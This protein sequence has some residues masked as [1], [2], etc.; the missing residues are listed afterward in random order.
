MRFDSNRQGDEPSASFLITISGSRTKRTTTSTT[1]KD[2]WATSESF[3]KI[4]KEEEKEEEG[5]GKRLSPVD[6]DRMK[7]LIEKK[8]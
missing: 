7:G 2:L 5:E 1:P 6:L 4:K 8:V 3:K